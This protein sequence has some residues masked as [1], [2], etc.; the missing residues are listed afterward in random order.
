MASTACCRNLQHASPCA[1]WSS[2]PS[3][4]KTARKPFAL[5]TGCT[6]MA[7]RLARRPSPCAP[8]CAGSSIPSR[9]IGR[10]RCCFAATRSCARPLPGC[11]AAPSDSSRPACRLRSRSPQRRLRLQCLHGFSDVMDTQ[12]G[13]PA[14]GS[15]ECHGERS[16]EPP[17]RIGLATDRP[18]EPLAGSS[19]DDGITE[20][21]E[22]ANAFYE[23]KIVVGRR[24]NKA[25]A[26]IYCDCVTRNASAHASLDTRC[27]KRLYLFKQARF[28]RL[29]IA[30]VGVAST[31]HDDDR[32]SECRGQRQRVRI[33]K[34]RRNIV[35]EPGAGVDSGAHHGC[36]SRIDGY[37]DARSG[38]PANHRDNAV[39]FFVDRD[40][41]RKRT[42]RF[43]SDIDHVG[44]FFVHPQP[45]LY[46]RP[47]IQM[48]TAVRE[49]VWRYIDDSHDER[50]SIAMRSKDAKQVRFC[51]HDRRPVTQTSCVRQGHGA[52]ATGNKKQP[53]N[54]RAAC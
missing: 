34:Q 52:G 54:C 29:L 36:P 2:A 31:I 42:R 17:T 43:A 5:I 47:G 4:A 13:S 48:H 21:S 8:P 41:R 44:A 18:H 45:S 3:M 1:P 20:S 49:R 23:W 33:V 32:T 14:F 53:Y 16:S 6:N 26:G 46:G 30:G 19:D 10:R 11:S 12:Y 24:P 25:D 7:I 38:E 28:G 37:E 22:F 51:C 50:P 9:T 15:R 39:Q 27:K 35:D 40:T